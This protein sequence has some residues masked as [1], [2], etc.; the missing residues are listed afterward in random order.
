[1]SQAGIASGGSG[2]GGSGIQTITGNS[3][4][5]VGPDGSNNINVVGSGVVSVAGNAGTNT[6]TISLAGTVA[7]TYTENAGTATPA[8]N[9][10]NI[11]GLNGISTSG[12]GSTVTI[13]STNGQIVTGFTVD[14]NTPPGTNPVVAN[15]SGIVTITGGQVATGTIGANVIQTNSLAANTYAIQIQRS[16]AVGASDSTKNGVSHFDSTKFT[17]DA[18]GF[19]S[20]N[21][22]AVGL[23]ITGNSG[24]ALSPVAGNWNIFGGPGVTTSGSGNTLTIN[25]V[26]FTDQGASISVTQDSGSYVTA[27]ITLTTPI[28]PAQGH[29]L[30]FVCTNASTLVIK[31]ADAQLIRIGS[32]ISSVGGTATSTS[33]G[34]SV[35]L[36]FRTADSTWYAVSV[37]G[38]W[39]MA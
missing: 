23:T 13:T 22:S 12:A 31:A 26:V 7:T 34:D 15:A 17:V 2:G 4:G 30:I 27:A 35:T 10:L 8:A 24:G 39:T 38:T 33:I 1:M 5:A 37:I 3:G 19:V 36:R 20:L 28:G 25:S 9:N 18:T 14:A 21:G 32:L 29:E 16:T 6:L 11:L